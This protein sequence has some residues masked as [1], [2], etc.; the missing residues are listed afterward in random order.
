MKVCSTDPVS[1]CTTCRLSVSDP[2]EM[3]ETTISREIYACICKDL[4]FVVVGAR[5]ELS[6]I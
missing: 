3:S 4:D 2:Q 6:A 1:D 5:N